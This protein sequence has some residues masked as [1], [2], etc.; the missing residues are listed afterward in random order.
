MP[1]PTAILAR[2]VLAGL[3][4]G[5]VPAAG[6]EGWNPWRRD[7]PPANPLT[8]KT[9]P[10]AA[11]PDDPL[12]FQV[13]VIRLRHRLRPD[14]PVEDVWGL[15]GADPVPHARAALWRAN[16]LRLGVGGAVAR[17]HLDALMTGTPDRTVRPSTLVVRENL[18][19]VVE[20]GGR[21]PELNVVWTDADGRLAGRRFETC[22]ARFRLVC[23]RDPA[24]PRAVCIALA[25][26][27]A[28]GEERMRY[29]RTDTGFTQQL[30]RDRFTVDG[31]EA[32]VSLA[33]G[34]LVLLGGR[35]SSEVSLG[36]AMFFER[37]GPDVWKETIL[38][39]AQAAGP[40][41]AAPPKGD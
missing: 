4:L 23:R 31:L 14:A 26:E 33:P 3:L 12:I 27:I 8:L 5:L 40:G 30:R 15:L 13:R 35:Q 25:P 6:C 21:R 10:L 22:S 1:R 11:D 2:A 41:A 39:A 37:R 34:R 32:E 7:E 9:M 24:D 38:V 29:V 17:D 36:G 20:I 19:F 18:D 28:Y 16:D